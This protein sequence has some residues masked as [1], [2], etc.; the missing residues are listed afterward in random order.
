M[1]RLWSGLTVRYL[2]IVLPPLTVK[3]SY[4]QHTAWNH[5][6][7]QYRC[8]LRHVY[9]HS[10]NLLNV[11]SDGLSSQQSLILGSASVG[12]SIW[13]CRVW[14]LFSVQQ[15]VKKELKLIGSVWMTPHI[16]PVVQQLSQWRV[17]RSLCQH[18]GFMSGPLFRRCLT[19][20]EWIKSSNN[21]FI[22]T[23]SQ[24]HNNIVFFP[25]KQTGT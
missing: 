10:C 15:R 3:G 14:N 24:T 4:A 21:S 23:V 20:Y 25:F 16:P 12:P 17:F 8:E 1:N 5:P 22:N 7:P 9:F 19:Q 2:L 13:S 6:N 18:R 11:K